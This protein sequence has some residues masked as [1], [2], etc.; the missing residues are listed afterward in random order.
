LTAVHGLEARFKLRPGHTE[1]ERRAAL[2]R[3]LTEPQHP[4]TWRSIVN[5][6]WQYHFGRG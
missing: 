6:V 2:A 3:W 4:L 1:G 5:R